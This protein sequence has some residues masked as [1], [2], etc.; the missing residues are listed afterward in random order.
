MPLTPV[1]VEK[2]VGDQSAPAVEAE[3]GGPTKDV[4]LTEY[5][6]FVGRRLL[7]FSPRKDFP[8]KFTVLESD[9][10]VNAF[11]LGNGNVYVTKGLLHL[12]RDEAELAEVIG[13]EIGHVANRHIA[14]KID[15]SIGV[16][17]L[18][19]LAE[20]IYAVKKGDKISKETQELINTANAVTQALVINGFG[21]SQ[22]LESDEDG[23]K[24]MV[25]AGYD[26]MGAVRVFETFQKKFG[27][28]KGLDVFFSSHPTASQ[29]ISDL[30]A[31]IKAK[32]PGVSGETFQDRYQSIVYGGESLSDWSSTGSVPTPVAIGAAAALAV[33]IGVVILS[34]R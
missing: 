26:P 1:F 9:K 13:H 19:A 30:Q 29:R 31:R 6:E 18:L 20:G 28:V 17:G 16:G 11:A 12:L 33:G 14:S 4:R 10:V 24:Y 32:Y 8:H 25:K 15:A 34:L 7:P 23:L 3:Y 27:D 2:A 22:E 21:R 5:V